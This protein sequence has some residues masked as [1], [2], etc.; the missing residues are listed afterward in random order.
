MI[1]D[2]LLLKS[3]CQKRLSFLIHVCV[4]LAKNMNWNSSK[5]GSY[6]YL[7]ICSWKNVE[8][9]VIVGYPSKEYYKN[10]FYNTPK[11]ERNEFT[12]VSRKK[13]K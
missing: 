1:A 9:I 2:N 11:K 10:L 12:G 8:S 7:E 5:N 3:S 4:T 13:R 6:E